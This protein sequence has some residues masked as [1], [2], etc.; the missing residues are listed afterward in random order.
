MPVR[1]HPRRRPRPPARP[2]AA[3]AK[4]GCRAA[5]LQRALWGDYAYQ[6]KTRRIV[7]IRGDAAGRAKPL[8]VQL[9]LEP[10]WKVGGAAG[11]G[12]EG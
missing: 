7:R 8:F 4:M 12:A 5:A 2:P 6:P 1:L 11:G 10:I 9:A 3:A